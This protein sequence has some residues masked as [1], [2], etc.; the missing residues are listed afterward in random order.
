VLGTVGGKEDVGEELLKRVT[1]VLGSIFDVISHSWLETLHELYRRRAE[2][3]DDLIPL[4]D[5][6]EEAELRRNRVCG[7]VKGTR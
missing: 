5:I 2:L 1:S 3:F 4:V 7:W 6:Y